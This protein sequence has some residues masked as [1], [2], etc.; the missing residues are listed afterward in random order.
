MSE[1]PHAAHHFDEHQRATIEAAMARIIPTDDTPGAREAGTIDFLE[2]YLSGIDYIFARPDGSGF[3]RLEG[4]TA[5]SWWQ[6]VEAARSKYAQ[7]VEDLDLLAKRQ[8]DVTFVELAE[9][10]QDEVLR[11]LDAR[12]RGV[13]TQGSTEIAYGME[14]ALQQT[15]AEADLDF[16]PLLVTHTRQG[17]LSDPIYGGNRDRI[18]WK[19]IGFPG[20]ASL[21]E[22]HNGTYS[23][24]DYF[25]D[26]RLHPGQEDN[27]DER[28]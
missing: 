3:E 8:H 21:A 18:G 24:L 5:E 7:G 27:D 11:T 20:P 15:N 10:Q 28:Q 13:E 6:R 12:S 9:D 1:T 4:R 16:F 25:A 14:P 22:V 26:N 19:V 17:F 23:T 2:R